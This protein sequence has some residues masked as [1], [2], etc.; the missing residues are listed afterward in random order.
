MLSCMCWVAPLSFSG[1]WNPNLT[2]GTL[3]LRVSLSFTF[4]YLATCYMGRSDSR[5]AALLDPLLD[6]S[7]PKRVENHG[8][9]NYI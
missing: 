3:T 8:R 6:L 4:Y 9:L 5:C 2:L 7:N 1:I